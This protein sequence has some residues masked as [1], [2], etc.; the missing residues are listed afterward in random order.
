MSLAAQFQFPRELSAPVVKSVIRDQRALPSFVPEVKSLPY[1]GV[2][3][4]RFLLSKGPIYMD[5]PYP[6]EDDAMI[7]IR[8]TLSTWLA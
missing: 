1:Y 3:M 5:L 2:R 6:L 4:P 8:F 7:T